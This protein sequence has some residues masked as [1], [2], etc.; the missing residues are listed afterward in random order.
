MAPPSASEEEVHLSRPPALALAVLTLAAAVL[1]YLILR[2]FV[3]ALAWA[4]A[5]AVVGHPVQR[6]LERRVRPSLAAGLAVLALGIAIVAPVFFAGQYLVKEAAR[7]Y[8]LATEQLQSG[9]WATTLQQHE[10]VSRV[11]QWIQEQADLGA[12]MQSIGGFAAQNAP[13]FLMGSAWAVAEIALTLFFVFFFLRDRAQLLD[14]VRSVIPLSERETDRLFV[15]VHDTILATVWANIATSA[16]QGTLGGIIFWLLGLPAPL[17]W[18]AVMFVL[19]LVPTLGSF[20]VWA[21]AAAYL[22]ISGSLGKAA[23][24]T[25]WGIGPVGMIDNVLYPVLVRTRLQMHTLT[26][27]VAVVGGVLAFGAAGLVIG[28]VTVAVAQ[29]LAPIWRRRTRRNRSLAAAA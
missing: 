27:F 2:P 19:S 5:L 25:G 1:C 8:K 16:L 15:R 28:P 10:R 11:V 13:G 12:V 29:S 21:P 18:G 24:L 7:A 3:P 6:W 23:L 22:A 14:G 26:A 20:V 17:A 4:L 9:E